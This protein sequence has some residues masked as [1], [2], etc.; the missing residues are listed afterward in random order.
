MEEV[1]QYLIVK[2]GEVEEVEQYLIVKMNWW[3]NPHSEWAI[4]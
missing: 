3:S 2:R 1:E 4:V